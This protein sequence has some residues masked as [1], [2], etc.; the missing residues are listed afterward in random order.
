LYNELLAALPSSTEAQRRQWAT[1]II[2]EDIAL[3]DLV[4]LVLAEQKVALRFLWLVSDVGIQDGKKLKGELPALFRFMAEHAPAHLHSFASWWHYAGVPEENEAQAIDCLFKW[5]LSA[6]TNVSIKTR[7][8]WVLVELSKK[9]P[10]L[11]QELKLSLRDQME[12]HSKDFR[13]RAEKILSELS[14]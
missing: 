1:T 7:A 3:S 5:F 10:E 12:K 11:K 4:P 13:K 2:A 8:L 6:G 9:Y 14:R